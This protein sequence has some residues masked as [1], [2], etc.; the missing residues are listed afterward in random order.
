VRAEPRTDIAASVAGG[1]WK[2]AGAEMARWSAAAL[3][4]M[5]CGTAAVALWRRLARQ[6]SRPLTP[7]P[8]LVV[9]VLAAGAAL[10]SR[11]AWRRQRRGIRPTALDRL[12]AVA[13]T[14]AVLAMGAALSLGDTNPTGLIGFW[15]VLGVG[16]F[17]NW[18][19]M[20]WRRVRGQPAVRICRVDPPQEPS[21]YGSPTESPPTGLPTKSPPALSPAE[22][23]PTMSP[24]ESPPTMS[25]AESPPTMSP[26]ESP[27]TMSLPSALPGEDVLQQLVR[28]RTADGNERLTGWLRIPFAAGQRTVSEHVAF[29]PPFDKTPQVTVEQ[30]DGP[31]VRVKTAQ[32]LPHGAR[33]DLKLAAVAE[34]PDVVILQFSARSPA[35]GWGTRGEG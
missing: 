34:E 21:P 17:A 16:E 8:L 1:P 6:L 5:L 15:L 3:V 25:P 30:L 2:Q 29:C 26:A 32:L 24:A 12:M 19:P 14:A 7:L 13:P 33:L 23:P 9:G 22:S 18:G 20:A 31:A 27:P 28:S 11:L 10:G 35:E 4:A